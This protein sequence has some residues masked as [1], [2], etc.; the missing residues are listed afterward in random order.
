MNV[1]FATLKLAVANK[2]NGNKVVQRCPNPFIP[3]LCP[4]PIPD[5]KKIAAT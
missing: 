1:S 2:A 3:K 5:P 4:N